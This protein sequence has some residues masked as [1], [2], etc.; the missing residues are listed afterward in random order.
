MARLCYQ[1][2]YRAPQH[3]TPSQPAGF[4]PIS[5]TP[6]PTRVME[7]VVVQRFFL[8]LPS[9]SLLL[10]NQFAFRPSGSPAAAIISFLHMV[11]SMLL[12]NPYVVVI[13][14]DFSKAVDTVRHFLLIEKLAQLSLP[15]HIYNSTS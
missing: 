8:S 6:V 7:R 11:I 9:P 3:P 1:I 12:T 14:I 5:I 2:A 15:D 10:S 4:R 13:S